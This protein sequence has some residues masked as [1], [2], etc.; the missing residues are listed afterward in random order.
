MS[1]PSN[2]I[3]PEVIREMMPPYQFSPD[4]LEATLAALPPPPPDASPDWRQARITR[5]M[6][7]VSTLMPA[8]AAQARTAADILIV[9]GLAATI[10]ARANAP[11]L[12]LPQMCR[13]AR[14]AG[15][16]VRT[17][18]GLVR[19]LERSQ[20][21]PAAFFGTV[22]AD[23]VDVAAVDKAWCGASRARPAAGPRPG[24][25]DG[26]AP[27]GRGETADGP[28]PAGMA[29]ST[30]GTCARGQGLPVVTTSEDGDGSAAAEGDI[31][32]GPAAVEEARG[33]GPVVTDGESGDGSAAPDGA[34]GDRAAV[35]ARQRVPASPGQDAGASPEWT[36]SR[37]D[38]GPGWTLDVVRPRT[39]GYAGAG[40][41]PGAAGR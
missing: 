29:G 15:E 13:V 9:R 3:T 35:T 27:G 1:Q 33:D 20:Q 39:G 37:L 16:L 26:G 40:A 23:A 25:E 14:A 28:A 21:K 2:G 32:D 4:L 17:A 34:S 19:S 22:L 24:G 12:T 31:E 7:E 36:T 30:L 18:G 8:N 11:D 6:Q 41:A 38:Q 5:L 10:A